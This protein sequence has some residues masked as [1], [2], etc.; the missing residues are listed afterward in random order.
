MPQI[1]ASKV[2]LFGLPIKIAMERVKEAR[3]EGIEVLVTDRFRNYIWRCQYFARELDLTLH[4]H[5]SWSADEDPTDW[6]F[7][8]LG[9]VGYLPTSGYTLQDHIPRET[10]SHP[11]VIN[12]ISAEGINLAIVNPN[13]WYQT[14]CIFRDSIPE[15][16]F[17]EFIGAVERHNLPVVF[18]T[19]HYLEYRLG[20]FRNLKHLPTKRAELMKLLEEGWEILGR[21]TKEI[22]L[23]DWTPTS[24][25]VFPGTGIAPLKEFC[26]LVR[27]TGW[28]GC[29]VPEVSPRLPISHSLDTLKRLRETVDSYFA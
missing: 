16:P 28:N 12:A 1:L 27:S 6:K 20:Y 9:L 15:L 4:F 7:K 23:N 11:V 10:D 19:Q 14:D 24:R 17:T 29:V 21:H 22:H 13:F 2:S 3:F 26:Q 25:N 8:V 5:Q 18:D